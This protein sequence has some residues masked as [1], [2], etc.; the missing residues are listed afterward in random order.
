MSKRSFFLSH[1]FNIIK[2]IACSEKGAKAHKET[3]IYGPRHLTWDSL[4]LFF[5]AR[6]VGAAVVVA[7]LLSYVFFIHTYI[8]DM[9]VYF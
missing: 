5:F 6:S 9:C 3:R 2:S 4:F 1:I 7:A 8:P